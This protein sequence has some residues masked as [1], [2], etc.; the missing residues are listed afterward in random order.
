MNDK[1][2]KFHDAHF[3]LICNQLKIYSDL[4]QVLIKKN[5]LEKATTILNLGTSLLKESNIRNSFFLVPYI[6]YYY[7]LNKN[8]IADKFLESTFDMNCKFLELAKS[9]SNIDKQKIRTSLWVINELDKLDNNKHPNK[10]MS[11]KI[12]KAKKEYLDYFG[13]SN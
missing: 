3:E 1:T 5:E 10:M 6:K 12:K 2:L 4:A 13:Y 7:Q 9:N 8:D 11:Q